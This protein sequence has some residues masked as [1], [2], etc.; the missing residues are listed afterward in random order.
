MK[1]HILYGGSWALLQIW[2]VTLIL[3]VN[4]AST[5]RQYNIGC[6]FVQRTKF[7]GP[8][9][10]EGTILKRG[11]HVLGDCCLFGFS[12][13]LFVCNKDPGKQISN[14][15]PARW[16]KSIKLKREEVGRQTGYYF[17]CRVLHRQQ[18]TTSISM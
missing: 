4:V 8:T 6:I 3:F 13:C 12:L 11:I 17:I 7:S 16:L 10:A 14:G 9:N 18:G 2:H 15:S 5:K 1:M